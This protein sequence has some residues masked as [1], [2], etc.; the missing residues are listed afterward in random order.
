MMCRMCGIMRSEKIILGIDPGYARV[1][2][3]VVR[4]SGSSCVCLGYGCFET[5]AD[6][7]IAQRLA[8]IEA[9]LVRIIKKF[10]PNDIAIEEL[11]W[12]RNVTT[13]IKVAMARGVVLVRAVE[14]TGRIY[15]YKPSQ[16]KH[17][18]TGVGNADKKQM[19]FMVQRILG[20]KEIPKPDDS[21]DA[22][23]VAITHAAIAGRV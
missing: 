1:G 19:Q 21:A 4:A 5:S 22:L 16:I 7:E 20:L 11:F 14:H 2:W 15:E 18:M 6:E 17:A 9:E 13:G 23:A 3:G 12:G 10:Q 8:L